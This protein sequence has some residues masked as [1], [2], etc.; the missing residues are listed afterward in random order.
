MPKP[1]RPHHSI[2]AC[3]RNSS[4][5]HTD[6]RGRK[7]LLFFDRL[8]A[9]QPAVEKSTHEDKHYQRSS[10]NEGASEHAFGVIG[11]VLRD[12]IGVVNATGPGGRI[13]SRGKVF[14]DQIQ[15]VGSRG[16]VD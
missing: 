4:L 6:T 13:N 2:V 12:G 7:T 9:C 8:D 3:I 10:E 14:K 1:S 11:G 15:F 5:G 16:D